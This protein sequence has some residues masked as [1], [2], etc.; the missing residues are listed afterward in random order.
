LQSDSVKLLKNAIHNFDN[1]S[2]CSTEKSNVLR[3]SSNDSDLNNTITFSVSN[4]SESL[5]EFEVM[6]SKKELGQISMQS[7][8]KLNTTSDDLCESDHS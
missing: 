4:R 7:N 1:F 8:D 2:D 5:H 3:S 6:R